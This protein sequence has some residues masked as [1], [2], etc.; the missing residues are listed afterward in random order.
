[1]PDEAILESPRA[2]KSRDL[3]EEDEEMRASYVEQQRR[4][5]CPD[6]GEAHETF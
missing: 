1:M 5:C 3:Q 4:M 2:E 6:C